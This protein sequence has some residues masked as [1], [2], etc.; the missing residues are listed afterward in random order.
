MVRDGDFNLPMDPYLGVAAFIEKLLNLDVQKKYF[1]VTC[2]EEKHFAYNRVG[3][4]QSSHEK[5]FFE[6]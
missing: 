1:V 6:A 5:Y 3:Y 4:V 2:G